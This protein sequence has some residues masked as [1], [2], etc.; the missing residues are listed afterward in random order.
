MLPQNIKIGVIGLGYV[1]LPLAVEFG[2]IIPTIG[3]D[4]D[5]SRL[6]ELKKGSDKTLE[7]SLDELYSAEKLSFSS[8]IFDLQS[9]NVFI[10]TVPTPID[11]RKAPDLSPIKNAQ[12]QLA[13][14][15]QKMMSLSMSR[16][17]ILVLRKIFARH[18]WRQSQA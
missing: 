11:D 17:S 14:C 10:V 12:I 2:K 8:S 1:G 16:P 5:T 13:K 6:E 4:I 18:F 7:V 3:Y 15:L 9:C